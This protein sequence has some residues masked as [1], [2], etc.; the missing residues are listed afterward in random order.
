MAED[1]HADAG[2]Q[3]KK[4]RIEIEQE[5]LAEVGERPGGGNVEGVEFVMPEVAVVGEEHEDN[6]K[7]E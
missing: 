4:R 7:D 5:V 1:R 2:K 6:V 3:I